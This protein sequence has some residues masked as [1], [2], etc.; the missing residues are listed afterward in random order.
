MQSA[1]EEQHWGTNEGL[2]ME[3]IPKLLDLAA[4][5]VAGPQACRAQ[6]EWMAARNAA[7]EPLTGRKAT[8]RGARL[9]VNPY[10]EEISDEKTS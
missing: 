4:A 2:G 7:P 3:R 6:F 10:A 9:V 5:S 1:P 8:A